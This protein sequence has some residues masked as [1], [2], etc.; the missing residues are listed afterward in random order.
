MNYVFWDIRDMSS[1]FSGVT[2]LTCLEYIRNHILN[3]SRKFHVNIIAF[4]SMACGQMTPT[5]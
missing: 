4:F 1:Y 5:Q 3:L 2:L